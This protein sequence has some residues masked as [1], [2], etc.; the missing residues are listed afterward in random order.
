ML[1]IVFLLVVPAFTLVG[2]NPS[3]LPILLLLLLAIILVLAADAY[4]LNQT[5]AQVRVT[6]VTPVSAYK[7]RPSRLSLNVELP[8]NLSHL[9]I[10]VTLPPT[11]ETP[12]PIMLA[13]RSATVDFDF[14]PHYR[15]EYHIQE[16]WLS[17]VSWQGL[18]RLRV[19][20]PIQLLAKVLPDLTKDPAS[21]KLFATFQQGQRVQRV[22]GRGREVERLRDYAPGDSF[23]EIYWKATARRG[24]PVTKVFQVERTQDIYAIVDG[25]RLGNRNQA[26]ER[27]VSA[28]LLLAIAAEKNS[29]NFGLLTFSDKIH[30]FVRASHGAGHF[31]RCREA[32]FALQPSSVSPDFDELF[33]FI[34]LR[35]RKRALLFFLT[36]LSDPLLAENFSRNSGLVARRHVVLVNQIADAGDRPLFTGVLP[37][38]VADVQTRLAG[39]LQWARLREL[40]KTLSHTGV[41]MTL[42]RP[43]QTSSEL[44]SQYMTVKQ[45]QLL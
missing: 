1:W 26:L 16:A 35:I 31:H 32:I 18:W 7:G 8:L 15:G 17:A 6:A 25:S 22:V 27:F 38:S 37:E 29:D 13:T 42:L 39:H 10:A 40:A 41:H 9:Q 14:T 33:T 5:L 28:S 19:K 11:F 2:V 43:D 12:Q 3:L 34:N 44:I 45:R 30:Q 23:E 4:R 24:S 21:R 36:D 20:R